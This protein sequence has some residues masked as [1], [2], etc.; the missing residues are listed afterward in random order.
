[1]ND[2]QLVPTQI[3]QKKENSVENTFETRKKII[4]ALKEKLEANPKVIAAFLA[5]ADA[6]DAI[7][8]YSDIDFDI[9]VNSENI[10]EVEKIVK[11]T[12]ECFSPIKTELSRTPSEGNHQVIY[13]FEK[14]SK[15]LHI[16]VLFITNPDKIDKS[17]GIN[18]LF[19]KN[20]AIKY[21]THS[22]IEIT[23]M[24]KDRVVSIEKFSELRGT[25]VERAIN[26]GNYLEAADK[27]RDLIL[28]NLIEV[29]RFQHCPEKSDYFLKHIDRDLPAEIVKE[30]EDLF[31]FS[32][33]DEL[34]EKYIKANELLLKTIEKLK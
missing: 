9:V 27:Y 8:E 14:I 3:I 29:I 28:K 2:K 13:Q 30:I 21:Q 32:S 31:Q 22:E 6:H 26:R 4:D 12:L 5:G 10:P 11:E 25:Y 18:I 20:N 1:M 7:D 19:D 34:R 16:D 23:E 15:F 17:S 24:I 33:L